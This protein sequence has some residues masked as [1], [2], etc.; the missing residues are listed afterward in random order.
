MWWEILCTQTID[1]DTTNNSQTAQERNECCLQKP[2]DKQNDCL[3][4][5]GGLLWKDTAGH[6]WAR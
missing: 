4:P 1:P 2:A 5:A 3:L 6:V